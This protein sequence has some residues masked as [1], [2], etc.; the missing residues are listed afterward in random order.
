MNPVYVVESTDMDAQPDEHN[1]EVIG[2]ALS[3][4]GI[5]Q[6]ISERFPS[7]SVQ[8]ESRLPN[9]NYEKTLNSG[10]RRGIYIWAGAFEVRE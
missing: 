10:G 8:S 1:N 7:Y 3:L 5:E 6:L 9:G 2:L 4:E